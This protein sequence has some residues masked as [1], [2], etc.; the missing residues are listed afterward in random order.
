MVYYYVRKLKKP[1]SITQHALMEL[2][3]SDFSLFLQPNSHLVLALITW[4]TRTSYIVP[5]LPWPLTFRNPSLKAGVLAD[6]NLL[7]LTQWFS[8]GHIWQCLFSQPD[9]GGGA[10]STQWVEARDAVNVLLCPGQPP[11]AE[12]HPPKMWIMPKL[13]SPTLEYWSND[14]EQVV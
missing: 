3:Q 1:S 13:R 8:T 4:C 5:T 11:V 12:N 7:V 10:I 6:L 9:R 14:L 2:K